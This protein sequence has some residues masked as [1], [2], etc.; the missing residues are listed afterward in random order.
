MTYLH[1]QKPAIIHGDLKS[2]NILIGDGY[3][4]KISD[5]GLSRVMQAYT[6]EIDHKLSGTVEYI[7]PEYL[8]GKKNTKTEKFDVYGFAISAW[9]IFSGKSFSK[10]FFDRKLI[11]VQVPKGARPRVGDMGEGVPARVVEIN[12]EVLASEQRRQT[13]V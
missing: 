10:E 4:A 5:F 8:V 1:Q 2:Q 13:N 3:R 11:S 9:E 6:S 12:S 7:A